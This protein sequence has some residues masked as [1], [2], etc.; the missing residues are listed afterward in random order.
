[1]TLARMAPTK[2]PGRSKC[3]DSEPRSGYEGTGQGGSRVEKGTGLEVVEGRVGGR[4]G[5]R[6]GGVALD[7]CHC[8]SCVTLKWLGQ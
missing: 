1:M 3:L 4:V 7:S 5:L 6:W 2:S 8:Q